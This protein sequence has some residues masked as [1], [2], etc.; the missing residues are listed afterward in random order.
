MSW[1]GTTQRSDR[2]L[3]EVFDQYGLVVCG[4]SA[5]WDEALREAILRS[6]GRRFA[7]YWLRRGPLGTQAQEIVN[8]RQAI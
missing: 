2:L 4:W 8:H 6:P 7:T 1:R 3:D 5:V